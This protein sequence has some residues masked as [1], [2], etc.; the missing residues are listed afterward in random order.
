MGR[1]RLEQ[2]NGEG[3]TGAAERGE[4]YWNSEA[5]RISLKQRN[6]KGLEQ[7]NWGGSD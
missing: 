4:S 3:Q 2:R 7:R 1:V 6:G 5:G